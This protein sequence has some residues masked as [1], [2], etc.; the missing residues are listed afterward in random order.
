M[1]HNKNEI[2]QEATS[3]SI[4]MLHLG[5]YLTYKL[6]L[7]FVITVAIAT[8]YKSSR[9]RFNSSRSFEINETDCESFGC[10]SFYSDEKSFLRV[11]GK[12]LA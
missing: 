9:F 2:S 12:L 1:E 4:F 5:E 6:L 10:L 3:A 8:G 7:L 11:F